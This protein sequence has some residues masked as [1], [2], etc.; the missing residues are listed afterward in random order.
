MIA[1]ILVF[2]AGL[3]LGACGGVLAMAL[4]AVG[5]DHD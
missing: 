2:F 4:V 5:A 3:F 1:L